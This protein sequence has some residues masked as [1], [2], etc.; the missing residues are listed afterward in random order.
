M[1]LSIVGG[2]N[3]DSSNLYHAVKKGAGS[4]NGIFDKGLDK[5]KVK[6]EN[7]KNGWASRPPEFHYEE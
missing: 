2:K 4:G 1:K 3:Q 6:R 7:D 5:T